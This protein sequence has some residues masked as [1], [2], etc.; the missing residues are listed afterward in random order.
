V[1]NRLSVVA[2]ICDCR[3]RLRR[4]ALSSSC[5]RIQRD[6]GAP[7]AC[8]APAISVKVC[9]DPSNGVRRRRAREGE[10][11]RGLEGAA[12]AAHE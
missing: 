8:E 6:I 1:A 4:R 10:P 3:R 7:A 5:R 9:D 11:D 2:E 12:P